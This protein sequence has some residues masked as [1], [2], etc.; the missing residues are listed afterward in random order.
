[1]TGDGLQSIRR[2]RGEMRLWR[3]RNKGQQEFTSRF[4][5]A[6]AVIMALVYICHTMYA[7]PHV[8]VSGVLWW[9]T[10]RCCKCSRRR[11]HRGESND[12]DYQRLSRQNGI[13]CGLA[14][15]MTAWYFALGILVMVIVFQV[16][17]YTRWTRYSAGCA[18]P[19][20]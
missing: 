6:L 11:L 2:M 16:G 10:R 3:L 14:F 4:F 5:G 12:K 17:G 13:A 7:Q 1:M 15:A 9:W 8:T 20:I 18:E 19:H